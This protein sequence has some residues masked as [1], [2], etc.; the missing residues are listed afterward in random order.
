MDDF[1]AIATNLV[2]EAFDG[3]T[4]AVGAMT[5][6]QASAY[7]EKFPIRIWVVAG[8]GEEN[9]VAISVN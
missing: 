9:A 6:E 2:N 5:A 7:A 3:L 8:M 4:K 1:E